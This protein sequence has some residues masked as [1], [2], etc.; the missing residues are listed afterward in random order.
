MFGGRIL[1]SSEGE[2]KGSETSALAR[3]ASACRSIAGRIIAPSLLVT[4]LASVLVTGCG[5][6][7]RSNLH[8]PS[9]NG[10]KILVSRIEKSKKDA[11]KYLTVVFEIRR[12]RDG[13]LL[14]TIETGASERM[15]WSARWLN[16]RTIELDSADVGTYCW[17][18]G[19]AGRWREVDC[20]ASGE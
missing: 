16:A 8:A 15:R 18:A 12:A 11:G 19:S 17:R 9:P 2:K 14:A 5:R 7:S 10:G 1:R 20:P 13:A 3:S 6:S 4:L